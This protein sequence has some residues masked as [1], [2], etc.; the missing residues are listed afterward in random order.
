M[1][2]VAPVLFWCV[3]QVTLLSLVAG[4]AEPVQPF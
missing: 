2:M 1:N 4:G 3:V